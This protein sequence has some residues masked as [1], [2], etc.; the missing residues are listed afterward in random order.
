[1]RAVSSNSPSV[2]SIL[3]DH[4]VT[5]QSIRPHAHVAAGVS[6]FVRYDPLEP[7][8]QSGA[9]GRMLPPN[10]QRS[11]MERIR[12][13]RFD[14]ARDV[15]AESGPMEEE[16]RT[17]FGTL[18]ELVR[19][20][21]YLFIK[22]AVVELL[23]WR[24]HSRKELIRKLQRKGF[25]R[26]GLEDVIDQL[27]ELGYQDDQRAA[28]SWVRSVMRSS[29]RSRAHLLAGLAERGYQRDVSL[30][31]VESYEQENPECFFQS[32]RRHIDKTVRNVN[33]SGQPLT[34]AQRKT[35]ISRLMRRGFSM[36][37]IQ[38]HFH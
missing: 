6:V 8:E 30:A 18:Q 24:D 5:V 13:V 11:Q 3:P 25:S 32:L 12:R 9:E 23:S 10:S 7:L 37:E 1:M 33:S 19:R 27:H 36:T 28:E 17:T 2:K 4:P 26:Q 29:G 31:A 20:S 21:E 14:V 15:F 35:V 16:F 22:P 34:E 38:Q